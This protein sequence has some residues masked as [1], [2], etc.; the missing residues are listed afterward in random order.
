MKD[1]AILME[2]IPFLSEE[3]A[4]QAAAFRK[5]TPQAWSEPTL[6]EGWTRK[7]VVAHLKLGADFYEKVVTGGLKGTVQPPYGAADRKEFLQKREPEMKRLL[8][9]SPDALVDEFEMEYRRFIRLV[10]SLGLEDL[11]APAW[12]PMG[13]IPVGHFAGMRLFELALHDWDI[14]AAGDPGAALRNNLLTPLLRAFPLMQVRF[15]NLRPA[16]KAPEGKIRFCPNEAA[17]WAIAVQHGRAEVAEDPE[18]ETE[19]AGEGEAFI[20]HTTGRLGWREAERQ[21][22]LTLSGDR[23]TAEALLDAVSVS[24]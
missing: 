2:P 9:L 19:V 13:A 23:P 1:P 20:L 21:G 16:A 12:H 24:Y 7:H 14:R 6:C 18:S 3:S 4:R 8:A 10:K 17:P 15:L 5:W 11:H 22:R